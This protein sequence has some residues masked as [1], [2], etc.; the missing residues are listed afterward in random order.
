[1]ENIKKFI[2]KYGRLILD[3]SVAAEVFAVLVYFV[4]GSITALLRGNFIFVLI[5]LLSSVIALA[6]IIVFNYFVYLAIDIRD[7]LKQVVNR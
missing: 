7:T 2:V 1:M 6:V 3:I 5:A 4:S